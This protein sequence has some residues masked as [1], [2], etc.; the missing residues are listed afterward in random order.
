MQKHKQS[1]EEWQVLLSTFN[2]M[3]FIEVALN[4]YE[5]DIFE[6][7]KFIETKFLETKELNQTRQ[8]IIINYFS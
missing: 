1:K 5:D 7:A 4:R 2:L 8:E 3:E 6:I